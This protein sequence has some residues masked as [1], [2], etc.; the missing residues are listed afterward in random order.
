MFCLFC[1]IPSVF[2]EVQN[3][4]VHS[5]MCMQKHMSNMHTCQT[6]TH[7][8]LKSMNKF[9]HKEAKGF[10]SQSEKAMKLSPLMSQ[11]RQIK[12]ESNRD[13][14]TLPLQILQVM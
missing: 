4:N 7:V 11:S 2:L 9:K 6:C 10:A 13:W 12:Q 5:C 8:N 1:P 3:N 14:F